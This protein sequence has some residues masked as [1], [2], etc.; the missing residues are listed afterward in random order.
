VVPLPP[1]QALGIAL[2]SYGGGLYWGINSDWDLMPDLHELIE[3]ID[4]S[5]R[6]LCRAADE[7]EG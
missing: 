6:E 4:L 5:F 7:A 2:F 3:A 1:E